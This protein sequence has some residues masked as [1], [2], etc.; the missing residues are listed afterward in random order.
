LVPNHDLP[1]RQIAK[2]PAMRGF[3]LS[4]GEGGIRTLDTLLTYTHFPGVRLQPLGHLTVTWIKSAALS[5]F[6]KAR[7]LPEAQWGSNGKSGPN[8]DLLSSHKARANCCRSG[9]RQISHEQSRQVGRRCP[10]ITAG[11]AE[12]NKANDLIFRPKAKPHFQAR[13]QRRGTGTPH[14]PDSN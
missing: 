2:S 5:R 14:G 12:I 10:V 3:L 6:L 1:H 11:R 4:G 7:R 13:A 9:I 8:G